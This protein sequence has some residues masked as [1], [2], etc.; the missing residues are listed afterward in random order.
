MQV[1]REPRITIITS[2]Y[3]S[4][5]YCLLLSAV[6][7]IN[8]F[9]TNVLLFQGRRCQ[10]WLNVSAV[11]VRRSITLSVRHTGVTPSLLPPH[12]TPDA[13]MRFS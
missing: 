1:G 13:C 2:I 3:L 12:V 5:Y 6:R 11:H 10:C 7:R 9:I 4:V 8:L